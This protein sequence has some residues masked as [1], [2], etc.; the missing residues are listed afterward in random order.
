M[1]MKKNAAALALIALAVMFSVA[2]FAAVSVAD[3]EGIVPL[4]DIPIDGD[5]IPIYIGDFYV[6]FLSEPYGQESGNNYEIW[7]W[8]IGILVTA[9]GLVLMFKPAWVKLD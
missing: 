5:D 1:R 4:D 2:A 7:V 6:E 8:I 9:F 3:V